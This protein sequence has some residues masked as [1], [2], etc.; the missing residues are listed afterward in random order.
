MNDEWPRLFRKTTRRI[1]CFNGGKLSQLALVSSARR[2]L[3]IHARID[4]RQLGATPQIDPFTC[5]YSSPKPLAKTKR[6]AS[7]FVPH[8]RDWIEFTR[9]RSLRCTS[10]IAIFGIARKLSRRYIRKITLYL[11]L[12]S[13]ISDSRSKTTAIKQSNVLYSRRSI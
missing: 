10:Q 9:V 6:A 1:G 3:F 2:C 12:R 8:R 4:H 5:F 11:L 7:F 13:A